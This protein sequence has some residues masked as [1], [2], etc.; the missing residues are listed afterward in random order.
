[1]ELL[2]IVVQG[3][4]GV[5]GTARIALGPGLTVLHPVDGREAVLTR[6]LLDLLYPAGTENTLA[7]LV[8][9]GAQQSRVGV[10][11]QGRDGQSYRIL[12]DAASGK[13]ALMRVQGAQQI[14]VTQSAAEIGQAVTAQLGFPQLDVVQGVFVTRR[15]DLP[16]QRRDAPKTA[17]GP[18]LAAPGPGRAD[19]PLPP[20]F[21]GG[22]GTSSREG[23]PLPPGFS[24]EGAPVSDVDAMSDAQRRARLAEIQD[25]LARATKLKDLEFELDG[26]QKKAFELEERM[27]PLET[28]RRSVKQ[29]EDAL[30]RFD[31]VAKVPDDFPQR[32]KAWKAEIAQLEREVAALDDEKDKLSTALSADVRDV[33]GV[34][35]EVKA[36]FE[37]PL[38]KYG[39]LAGVGAIVVGVVG[40]FVAPALRWVAVADILGFGVALVGGW[41]FVNLLEST[42][43]VKRKLDRAV[44]AHK[45]LATKLD[46]TR[47]TMRSE[48]AGHGV[49]PDHVAEVEERLA[50]YRDALALRQRAEEALRA[51]SQGQDLS[52]LESERAEVGRRAKAIEEELFQMGGY[53]GD[54]EALKSEARAIEDQL[55][56]RT[57][58]QKAAVPAPFAAAERGGPAGAAPGLVEDHV[59]KM[60]RT[61]RDV[62]L[63]DVDGVVRRVQ[64]RAAQYL[65]A[66]SDERFARIDF[67]AQGE[68][69]LHEMSTGQDVPYAM[70][71]PGDRDLVY[72]SVKLTI[73]EA[74]AQQGR[75][76][77]VLER[78]LDGF[79]DSKTPLLVRVLQFLSGITQVFLAT[80][81]PGLAQA[82]Q[83]K[84]SLP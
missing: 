79:P 34:G 42:Q 1:M 84:V 57:P 13:R 28:L 44:D 53:L 25:I 16:S 69:S 21:T 6:V 37:D 30:R 7:A 10:L 68:C 33:R 9:P 36:A 35:D 20:G 58:A 56:G 63:T 83:T 52:S 11:L 73:A 22:G 81:K 24:D 45:K 59:A 74:A 62:F 78:A 39:V 40:A 82:A 55:A 76:P 12:G 50:Q 19:R 2:E 49:D 77:I 51:Q 66:L 47:S 38:V 54:M 29:A 61:A 71:T 46:L 5:P 43:G 60:V 64:A 48:L 18:N 75:M 32:V 80:S 15:D 4:T 72:L 27:R 26:L 23:K 65:F 8:Q 3:V 70:L 17:S 14:P 41:R 67:G 31:D